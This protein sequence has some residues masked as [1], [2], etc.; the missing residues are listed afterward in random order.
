MYGREI[1]AEHSKRVITYK[2]RTFYVG[3]RR[4]SR[5]PSGF[6]LGGRGRQLRRD[7]QILGLEKG[8]DREQVF[9]GRRNVEGAWCYR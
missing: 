3:K 8:D 4:C 5:C 6:I 9:L 7:E 1:R 2:V